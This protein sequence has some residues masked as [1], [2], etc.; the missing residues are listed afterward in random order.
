M[1]E[2]RDDQGNKVERVRRRRLCTQPMSPETAGTLREAMISVVTDG[3]ASRLDDGLDGFEVGGKTGTAQLG[4]DPTAVARVDHRLRRPARR[5]AAR[6]GRG[7]RR[8]AA[9]RERADW[10]PGGRAH[11][12]Q[13]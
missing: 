8:G 7:D 12:R 11:R 5:D 2:I 9:G 3:T 1:R 4:T 13:R 10:W 6:G